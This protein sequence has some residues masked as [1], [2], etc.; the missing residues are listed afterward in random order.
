M[1][2]VVPL[3]L[4]C[5]FMSLPAC[6]AGRGAPPPPA[7]ECGEAPA[8]FREAVNRFLLERFPGRVLLRDAIIHSPGPVRLVRPDG[9]SVCGHAGR[10]TVR[11]R[12]DADS[13]WQRKS[14]RY[15]I[16]D[17]VVTAIDESPNVPLFPEK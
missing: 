10:L 3:L 4:A 16:Q 2:T 9:E 11:V 13:P 12:E 7:P 5:L 14:F 15:F 1:R 6:A 8:D 17:G